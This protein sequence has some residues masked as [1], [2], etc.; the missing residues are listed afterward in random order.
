MLICLI[1]AV[2]QNNLIGSQNKLPW[3]LPEDLSYFKETT[4]HHTVVMGRKTFQSIGRKLPNR[5][6]IIISSSMQGQDVITAPQELF[7]L[8]LEGKVFIIGGASI[9]SYFLPY[10]H[11][12]YLT[13]IEETFLGDCYFPAINWRDWQLMSEHSKLPDAKNPFGRKY[14]LYKQYQPDIYQE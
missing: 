6:N 3:H 9:Y 2:D 10:A 5:R 11:Y 4:V 8:S 12:L 13:H 14:C 7:S 1:C